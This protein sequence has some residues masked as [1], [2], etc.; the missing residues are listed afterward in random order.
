MAATGLEE[1]PPGSNTGFRVASVAAA[2]VVLI[3]VL[4]YFLTGGGAE[5]FD[6]KVALRTYLG[7]AEGLTQNSPVRLNGV[8]VGNIRRVSV[9]EEHNPQRAA[10]IEMSV[11]E[12]FLS[13]IPVDSIASVTADNLLGDKYIDI[14]AGRSSATISDN[15][16]IKSLV[17]TEFNGADI[18]VNMQQVLARVDSLLTQ[19]ERGDTRL[20]RFF[21]DETFYNSVRE[22]LAGIQN[23]ITKIA[24]AKTPA[25]QMF[26]TDKLYRSLEEP[27]LA[28]DKMLASMQKGEGPAGKML[29]DASQ[30]N[31]MTAS[32]RDVRT[33]L[34]GYTK[35]PMLRDETLYNNWVAFATS[36][37][38]SIDDFDQGKGKIGHEFVNVQ[39]YQ[40]LNGTSRSMRDFMK[41]FREDPR[42]YLRIKVF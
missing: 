6:S 31:A 17:Q 1:I 34:A 5:L 26:F 11:H 27:I 39:L 41:D 3:L 4:S 18:I 32:L 13:R 20:G 30:Y 22:Q 19:I 37:N 35:A 36:L 9:S 38:K 29:N 42:K 7:D 23:A 21:R 25:G 2:A 10:L 12:R 24:S 15:G 33:A 16:E 14:Q 28:I 8:R 40:S